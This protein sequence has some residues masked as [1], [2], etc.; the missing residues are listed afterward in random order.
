MGDVMESYNK[1]TGKKWTVMSELFVRYID[2]KLS[3]SLF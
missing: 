2:V 1:N 3:L